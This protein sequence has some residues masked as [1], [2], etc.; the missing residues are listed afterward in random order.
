[1]FW[2]WEEAPVI[3]KDRLFKSI[4][5]DIADDVVLN[6]EEETNLNITNTKTEVN[7]KDTELNVTNSVDLNLDCKKI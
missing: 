6:I 2:L 7:I 3:Y 5:I 1:M 4:D